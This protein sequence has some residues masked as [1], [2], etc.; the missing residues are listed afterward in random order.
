MIF[1]ID[2]LIF[3]NFANHCVELEATS[4]Q[5]PKKVEKSGKKGPIWEYFW[6]MFRSKS[7]SQMQLRFGVDFV[8]ML[9]DFGGHLG[10][11][12]IRFCKD[13]L[14]SRKVRF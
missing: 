8:S 13:F 12:F 11:I 7:E 9:D 4:H 10:D 14:H 2:S 3:H 6:S 1:M 5:N